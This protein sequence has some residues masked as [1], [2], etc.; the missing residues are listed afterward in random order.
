[1]HE[2]NPKRRNPGWRMA[3]KVLAHTTGGGFVDNIPRMLSKNCVVFI[4]KG[5]WKTPAIFRLLQ[6]KGGVPQDELYQ[7]FNMGIGMTIIVAADCA[8]KILKHIRQ[9]QY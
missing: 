1:M 7:A 4:R 3:I 6:A 2:F 9:Q 8:E 5:S